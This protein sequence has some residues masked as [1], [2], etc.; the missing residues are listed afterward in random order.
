MA[1]ATYYRH[2]NNQFRSGRIFFIT[3]LISSRE[4]WIHWLD[5][6]ARH[7]AAN[8]I[9]ID[10]DLFK[11]MNWSAHGVKRF[12]SDLPLLWRRSPTATLPAMPLLHDLLASWRVESLT[13]LLIDIVPNYFEGAFVTVRDVRRVPVKSRPVTEAE[14]MHMAA[15]YDGLS[16][17]SPVDIHQHNVQ[18][19]VGLLQCFRSFSYYLV[20]ACAFILGEAYIVFFC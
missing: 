15:S 3:S 14:R 9:W 18:S 6:F 5:N 2:V 10:R 19:S 1:P 17:F 12:T 4:T 16:C 13:R 7:Y 20:S 11:V 8:G